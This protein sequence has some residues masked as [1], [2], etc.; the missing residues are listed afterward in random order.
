MPAI[1]TS[2]TSTH[3][4]QRIHRDYMEVLHPFSKE[5]R[6]QKAFR[7]GCVKVSAQ[8]HGE[9]PLEELEKPLDMVVQPKR[10]DK[11]TNTTQKKIKS[12]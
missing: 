6:K 8:V 3:L 7:D 10:G 4:D 2:D 11:T 5:E 1:G 12:Y 9:L